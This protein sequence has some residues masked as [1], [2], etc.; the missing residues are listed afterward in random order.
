VPKGA[1]A[2]TLDV[3][4]L[5]KI[6]SA[7]AKYLPGT[8]EQRVASIQNWMRT[9]ASSEALQA[10]ALDPSGLA[11]AMLEWGMYVARNPEVIKKIAKDVLAERAAQNAQHI[12]QQYAAAEWQRQIDA[13]RAE[14]ALEYQR[15]RDAEAAR[16]MGQAVLNA[17]LAKIRGIYG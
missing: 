15:A 11:Q 2:S 3:A 1:K 9:V 17:N 12:R 8:S 10:N 7:W 14:Q 13:Q 6:V 16:E 4:A 5:E